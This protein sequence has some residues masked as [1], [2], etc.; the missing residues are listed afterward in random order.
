MISSQTK[1]EQELTIA[2]P[3]NACVAETVHQRWAKA[4]RSQTEREDKKGF[5]AMWYLIARNAV[6]PLFSDG[7]VARN[8][9]HQPSSVGW[10]GW[11]AKLAATPSTLPWCKVR[12]GWVSSQS[13]LRYWW[14]QPSGWEAVWGDKSHARFCRPAEWVTAPLSLT[15]WLR[16]R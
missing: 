5:Q 8:R 3:F 16:K 9:P 10:E 12:D 15:F 7:R 11:V 13:S 14:Q 1:D 2:L 6:I 4:A